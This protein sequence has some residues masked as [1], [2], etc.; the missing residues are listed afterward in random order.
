MTAQWAIHHL[1]RLILHLPELAIVLP[2]STSV[3]IVEAGVHL[4]VQLQSRLVELSLFR[5]QYVVGNRVWAVEG[6]VAHLKGSIAEE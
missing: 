5:C 2:H 6:A 3:H 4:P 1:S